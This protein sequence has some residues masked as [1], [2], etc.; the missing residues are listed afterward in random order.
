LAARG[1][2]RWPEDGIARAVVHHRR[3]GVDISTLSLN[4]I[5]FCWQSPF[6]SRVY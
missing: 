4:L 2:Q 6:S 1:Q 5:F 3:T